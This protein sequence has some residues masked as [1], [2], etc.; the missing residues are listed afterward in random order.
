MQKRH[1]HFTK[2]KIQRIYTTERVQ[3]GN[4]KETFERRGEEHIKVMNSK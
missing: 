3:L 4:P 1:G 2:M